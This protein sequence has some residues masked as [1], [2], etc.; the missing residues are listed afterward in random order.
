MT[1]YALSI[2]F[3]S[4]IMVN[5]AGTDAGTVSSA[6]SPNTR[7]AARQNLVAP[8]RGPRSFAVHDARVSVSIT[9]PSGCSVAGK[10][11]FSGG[12]YSNVPGGIGAGILGG[13]N[14]RSCD[15]SSSVSGGDYNT[16]GGDGASYDSSIGSGQSNALTDSPYAF[17]GAGYNNL[18]GRATG[19]VGSSESAIIGG[20]F[21][22][23]GAAGSFI[24]A[25]YA[26][27]I[28]GQAVENAMGSSSFIGAG[29]N[30]SIAADWAVVTGGYNNSNTANYA[31]VAGGYNNA[32]TGIQA[33]V[34]GGYGNVASGRN[35]VVPGGAYNAATGLDSFAAGNA[36]KATYDGTFVWSD[37]SATS[38][39]ASTATNQFLARAA[40]GFYLYSSANLKSGVR[41]APGS[42]SWSSLSDR[43]AKTNVENINASRILAKVAALPISEWSYSAQGTSVRHLGPMAQDFR[44]AFGLGEDEKHISAVDEEGVALAAIKALQA[45]VAAKDRELSDLDFKY[46]RLEHRL[47]AL[48]ADNHI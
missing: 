43:A 13:T 41:L 20:Q 7:S 22:A 9:Y 30:N 48:E 34:G 45:E 6:T 44:A 28:V 12:G 4:L 5:A 1:H 40:G 2:I 29:D 46:T 15:N 11:S 10:D 21:N 25:G 19:S 27:T 14:G 35:A 18:I 26:N 38:G 24:G 37:Y 23:I 39:I 31:T 17:M 47:E 8:Y 32:V 3:G 42:G 33:S 36:A 16:L